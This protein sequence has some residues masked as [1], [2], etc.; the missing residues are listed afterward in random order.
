L[1]LRAT[2][3]REDY[4]RQGEHYWN[5]HCGCSHDFPPENRAPF[6]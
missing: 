1:C 2:P 4:R 5:K 3:R 6:D